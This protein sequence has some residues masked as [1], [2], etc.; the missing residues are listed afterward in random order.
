MKNKRSILNRFLCMVMAFMIVFT[1]VFTSDLKSKNI[2]QAA[3]SF[4]F[5]SYSGSINY[6]GSGLD[7]RFEGTFGRTVR[8]GEKIYFTA[9]P[10]EFTRSDELATV[11]DGGLPAGIEELRNKIIYDVNSGKE[12]GRFVNLSLIHI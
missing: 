2:S 4:P 5:S 7:V 6:N 9:R 12:I 11:R 1:T 3:G 10:T 8:K